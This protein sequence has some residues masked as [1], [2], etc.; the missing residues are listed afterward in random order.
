MYPYITIRGVKLYMTGIGIVV[1]FLAFVGIVW[2]LSKKYLQS[3]WRFF[4]WL[5]I[6]I[7][8]V[9]FLWSYVQFVLSTQHILPMSWPDFLRILSPYDYNFNYI[10]ILIWVLIALWIFF[11][12]IKTIEN[13]KIWGDIFFFAFSLSIVP[14]GIF[15]LLWDNF[16]G[17][18]TGSFMGMKSLHS[19]SQRNKFD[20]V[21]PIGLFLS[22][23]T[24]VTSLFIRIKSKSGERKGLGM[25]WFAIL[26]VVINAVLM[27][28]QYPR[29]MVISFG[30]I[31]L[32]I[33]QH[34]SFFVIMFC[35]YLYK[36]RNHKTITV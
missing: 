8:L 3:F 20:W 2:Y 28:E 15:L 13:K 35:L 7:S 17:A 10:G 32:D 6:L 36:K 33:K 11:R 22:L 14:L 24:L 4:Y 21:L 19:E 30:P 9:Y 26:L 23:G 5:P 27:M 18:N 31:H 29:Y 1:S 12:E 25:L 34:L 16:I